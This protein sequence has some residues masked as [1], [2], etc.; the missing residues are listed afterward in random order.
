MILHFLTTAVTLTSC[1]CSTYDWT[2]VGDSIT[3]ALLFDAKSDEFAS[4]SSQFKTQLPLRSVARMRAITPSRLK[5]SAQCLAGVRFPKKGVALL[6]VRNMGKRTHLRENFIGDSITHALLFDAISDEFAS[7]S[8]QFET[9]LPLPSVARKPATS[10]PATTP[11]RSFV[12][13]NNLPTT[14][15]SPAKNHVSTKQSSLGHHVLPP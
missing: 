2:I 4:H 11:S 14:M 6:R 5:N 3:P 9:P 13:G 15:S 1:Y 8:F 12:K 10:L 7:R